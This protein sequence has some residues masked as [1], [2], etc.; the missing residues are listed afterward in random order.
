MVIIKNKT[1]VNVQTPA[2][3]ENCNRIFNA[4]ALEISK[5]GGTAKLVSI[6]LAGSK[7]TLTFN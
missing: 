5:V 2:R 4:T 6:A 3:V 7:T 1:G